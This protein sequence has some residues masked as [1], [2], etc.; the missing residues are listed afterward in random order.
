M[1]ATS[2]SLLNPMPRLARQWGGLNDA[3]R[4]MLLMGVATFCFPAMQAMI[5]L[6]GNDMDPIEIAFFR[7]LFGFVA[8][9]PVFM[10][11]G[12][13]ILRTA[14]P[15]GQIFRGSLQGI[16][17][18]AMFTGVTLVPLSMATSLSFT[19]PL[20]AT[21]LAAIFLGERIRIRRILALCA[22]LLGMIIVLRPG[23][24]PME[25]MVQLLPF[26][27]V[28]APLMIVGASFLWGTAITAIKSMVKTES[29]V[30]MTAYMGITMTPITLIPALYV[31]TW[32]T[33]EQ[34]GWLLGI[35]IIGTAGHVAF[36]QAMKSAD[37]SAV[38][39]LDFMRLVWASL[40]AFIAFGEVPD[41]W[42]WIG[43]SVIFAAATYIAIREAS[44]ARAKRLQAG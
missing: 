42:S 30:T 40:I 41:L 37:S 32:P 28:P 4:S 21:L 19:A 9:A 18:L 44:L 26:L 34:Y 20:F 1:P 29:S 43:G 7:N 39:P 33:L 38:L 10:R 16:G 17:M 14:R 27:A 5:R 23:V 25:P 6:V 24:V 12:F 3:A 11:Q 35:G 22:G 13:G 31:W 2:I 36:A 15:F 8:F